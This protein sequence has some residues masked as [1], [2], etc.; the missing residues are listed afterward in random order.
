M[1]AMKSGMPTGENQLSGIAHESWLTINW[2][3]GRDAAN[4][5]L[6]SDRWADMVEWVTDMVTPTV[7]DPDL[8]YVEDREIFAFFPCLNGIPMRA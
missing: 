6:T 2:C 3:Y 1:H 4:A 7:D 5:C 8:Y